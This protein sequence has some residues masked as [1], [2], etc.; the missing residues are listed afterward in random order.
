MK[1][2]KLNRCSSRDMS[3]EF[4]RTPEAERLLSQLP[5]TKPSSI[6]LNSYKIEASIQNLHLFK[7]QTTSQLSLVILL[8]L[9]EHSVVFISS[10]VNVLSNLSLMLLNMI[11]PFKWLHP[12]VSSIPHRALDVLYSPVPFLGGIVFTQEHANNTLPELANEHNNITFVQISEETLNILNLEH[13]T[14]IVQSPTF[15]YL[16]KLVNQKLSQ[17]EVTR[18]PLINSPP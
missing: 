15:Q 4:L 7:P 10:S 17:N 11:L 8:L 13:H 3:L 16:S 14:K 5:T 1:N 2:Y 9:L 12:F 18:I 6:K